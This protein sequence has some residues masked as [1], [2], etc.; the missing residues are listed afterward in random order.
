MNTYLYKLNLLFKRIVCYE[1]PLRVGLVKY[2]SDKYKTFRPHYECILYEACLEAKKLGIDKVSVLELGVA[3]GNGIIS[4]EK[5]KK[6]IQKILDMS[7]DIYGFDYGTGLPKTEMYEDLPFV[8]RE[9]QYA[10]N[11]EELEK[12]ISSKIFY[13]DVKDTIDGLLELKINKICCIIIDVDL[14]SSTIN[15]LN[16]IPKIKDY[17]LPRVYCYFDDLYFE[18]HVTH[19]NGELKAI[20]EFNE[21]F[22]DF[23]LG[24]P[25]DSIKNFKFPLAN[26]LLYSL[27]SF[28]NE[29]YNNYIGMHDESSLSLGSTK[30]RSILD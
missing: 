23:K 12:K 25:I 18:N 9:G 13:G 19:F 26:G 10:S 24:V 30:V 27:H 20:A 1:K 14:Y 2:L 29:L 16:Q 4:L 3:G 7:I 17:L 5:Y 21:N 22:S 6:R 15:F 11:K 8:W 28:K